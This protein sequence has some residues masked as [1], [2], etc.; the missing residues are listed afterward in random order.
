MFCSVATTSESSIAKL[1]VL[2][3]LGFGLEADMKWFS[4]DSKT[5]AENNCVPMPKVN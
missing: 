1:L 4:V 2:A 5:Y 3:N